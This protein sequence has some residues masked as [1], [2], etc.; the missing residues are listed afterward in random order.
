MKDLFVITDGSGNITF[1]QVDVTGKDTDEI[2]DELNTKG[3]ENYA[4]VRKT[5]RNL[6]QL[7]LAL[8]VLEK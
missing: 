1:K 8:N 5:D 6:E 2:E 7:K 3:H 4:L